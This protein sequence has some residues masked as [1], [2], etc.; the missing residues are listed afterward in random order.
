MDAPT[1]WVR[2]SGQYALD[3]D[4]SN[5][6][7]NCGTSQGLKPTGFTYSAWIKPNAQNFAYNQ[8]MGWDAG[9]SNTAV[10]TLLLKS[11]LKLAL[12]V[13]GGPFG[14]YD[15]NGVFTLSSGL[16]YHV[17]ATLTPT[18]A[19]G[20]VNGV[21]DR[22]VTGGTANISAG[23]FWIGGQNGYSGGTSRFFSGQMDDIAVWNR[24][25]SAAEI[26]LLSQRRGIAYEARRQDFGEA[27]F[28]AY[29]ARQQTQLIGGGV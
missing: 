14:T 6:Y 19:V 23:A 26:K 21:V 13:A 5:D 17:A 22:S 1:D 24:A 3:F 4:G 25:L 2:S 9:A 18:A 28:R 16:W 7:V 11:N 27:A 15:G 20:Y 10:C 8:I 29:W 12:Y